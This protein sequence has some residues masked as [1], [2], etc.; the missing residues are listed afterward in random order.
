MEH[1]KYLVFVKMEHLVRI[2]VEEYEALERL[3]KII[4]TNV[5]NEK[6]Q[7]LDQ[8]HLEDLE[9]DLMMKKRIKSKGGQTKKSRTKAPAW[10]NDFIRNRFSKLE[11]EVSSLRSDFDRVIE[12]NE[13][14]R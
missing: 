13:L 9:V 3:V 8:N 1:Q 12:L 10:F 2:I 4:E 11:K 14:Q 5:K 6:I 7:D